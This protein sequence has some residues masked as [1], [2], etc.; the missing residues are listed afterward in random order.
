L[1]GKPT[2]IDVAR[3][4]GVSRQTVSRVINEKDE[5][6]A[7][8]RQRVL[9]AID[10]LGY[11]PNAVARS[12]VRGRTCTLG[13]ISPNLSDFTLANIIEGAQAEARR[14]GYLILTGSARTADD[15]APLL[16]E[17]LHRRV[18]GLMVLNPRID[19]RYHHF[20][21]LAEAGTPVVYLN[22]TPDG[23]PVSSVRCDDHEGGYHAT[24]HLLQLGH[25]TIATVLGPDNEECTFDRLDGYRQAL[26]E[27]GLAADP[28]LQEQGDWSATSGYMAT[29]RLLAA[30]LPFTAIFSQNDQMAVGAIRALREAGRRVPNDVSIVG[31][32]DI[33]LA[34]YFD[35]PLTTLRQPMHESGQQAARLLVE[36]IQDPGRPPELVL[37]HA[38]LVER[39]SCAPPPG[40]TV[41]APTNSMP[42]EVS[43]EPMPVGNSPARA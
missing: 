14:L 24:R 31:F 43:I 23:A 38:R 22:N 9:D 21:P 42:K 33:P 34:S 29:Q 15:V 7:E 12:M 30:G 25:R 17:M 18:D 39:A 19:A 3:W 11:R 1:P 16:E 10:A 35:P 2:I 6:T 13:C 5:V 4:A 8:T 26:A 41:V 37:I 36:K 32:D 40:G 20:L 28:G 27:A